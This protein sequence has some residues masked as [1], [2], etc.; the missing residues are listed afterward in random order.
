MQLLLL[1]RSL[2]LIT[3]TMVQAKDAGLPIPEHMSR[4]FKFSEADRAFVKRNWYDLPIADFKTFKIPHGDGGTEV[5]KQRLQ[6]RQAGYRVSGVTAPLAGPLGK[7]RPLL[8]TIPVGREHYR[9]PAWPL[10]QERKQVN[11]PVA[12]SQNRGPRAVGEPMKG[13]FFNFTPLTAAPSSIFE[14]QKIRFRY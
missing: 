1:P 10:D 4:S 2:G 14:H 8:P 13:E 5:Y 6:D 3:F 12:T 11:V 7:I 9:T